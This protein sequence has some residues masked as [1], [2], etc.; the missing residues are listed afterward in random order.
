M[1]TPPFNCGSSSPQQQSPGS[2]VKSQMWLEPWVGKGCL[3]G[4]KQG[5]GSEE[6]D[7]LTTNAVSA[8]SG[9]P[10]SCSPQLP[11][12]VWQ[13]WFW[14]FPN[15]RSA[16]DREAAVPFSKTQKSLLK[17]RGRRV[18]T[19]APVTPHLSPAL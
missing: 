8:E 14:G 17:V 3:G 4:T 1:A 10:R 9:I 18:S 15:T 12:K 11:T 19:A 6:E 16:G 5:A 13:Q 7:L 2:T